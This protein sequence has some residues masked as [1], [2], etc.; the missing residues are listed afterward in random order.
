MK[1][2]F[3]NV[4]HCVSCRSC[5]INCALNR[6]SLL[7]QLL[8]AIY[9]ELSPIARIRVEYFGI[10]RGFPIQCRHC[11]D[12]PCI[13]ACPSDA[14]YRDSEDLVLIRDERCIGC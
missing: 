2:I 4:D 11:K 6:S 12:A 8:H 9:E 1:F 3:I 7:R 13:G 5:E 10:D 14:L